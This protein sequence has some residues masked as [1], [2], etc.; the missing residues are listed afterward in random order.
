MA[1]SSNTAGNIKVDGKDNA[2]VSAHVGD[3]INVYQ[4]EDRCIADLRTTD[5]RDDKTR[6]EETKGGL[7]KDSY[8]WIIDHNDFRHWRDDKQ[9][10]LLWVKG[11]AGKGKTMLLCGI[12]DHLRSMTQLVDPNLTPLLSF[13]FCQGTDSRINNATSVL[14][15]LIY[16]LVEQQQS[17]LS[18]VKKK[19][20]H[21]GKK[22]FE[23]ENSWIALSEIFINILQA[24]RSNTVYLIVDALDECEI[25]LPQLLDLIDQTSSL[26][27]RI[28]WIVSSRNRPDIERKLRVDVSRLRLSLELKENAECV[29]QAVDTYIRH[30]VSELS[31]I[32]DDEDLQQQIQE[33]MHEK[34]NGT[35][36]WVSL[37]VKELRDVE[38]WEALDVIDEM[39]TD[40]KQVYARMMRQIQG[41]KRDQPALCR[42]L[43]ATITV[44]YRPLRLK[45]LGTLS[46]LPKQI[47]EKLP[48]IIRI[49]ELC[50]SFLTIR[51]ESVYI[52]H[53]SAKDFLI[54]DAFN[55]VFPDGDTSVHHSVL[56]SSLDILFEKLKRNIYDLS[57]FGSVDNPKPPDPDPLAVAGYSCVYWIDHACEAVF[58]YLDII[59]ENGQVSEFLQTHFLYWLESLSLLRK[60]ADGSVSVRKL[61]RK[62]EVGRP[63]RP[64]MQL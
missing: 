56:L 27:K 38:S 52:I 53:Q 7:L 50:S 11:D 28:K 44:A 16:L 63:K 33:K 22:L 60:L 19:Y 40:L 58:N 37:V 36:L 42:M 20:D 46:G 29:S 35:F 41:L 24:L 54:N 30:S 23:D 8:M 31:S 4:T 55:S 62:V 26:S 17:L 61:R 3:N 14:C 6:I 57:T 12:I 51:D 13:F 47:S 34:A 9:C 49:V 2:R 32:Q 18:H 48:S 21:A 5:P 39:P 25:G 10:S 43:L 59:S 15:G 64:K 1:A 45:E